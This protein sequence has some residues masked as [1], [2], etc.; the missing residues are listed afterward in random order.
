MMKRV[1]SLSRF[2]FSLGVSVLVHGIL[3]GTAAWWG[4]QHRTAA[5]V[6]VSEPTTL[7]LLAAPAVV[8]ETIRE[9]MA[10]EVRLPL[11]PVELP[12]APDPVVPAAEPLPTPVAEAIVAVP[13]AAV[14]SLVAEK[15]PPPIEAHGDASSPVPGLD[16]TTAN[17]KPT[18][19]AHPDYR[20]NPEPDYPVAARRRGQQGTVVLLVMVDAGGKPTEISVQQTSGFELLDQAAVR[21]V[22]TWEFEPARVGTTP[23]ASRI[24][25]PVRFT[26]A[27]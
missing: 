3:L 14:E 4:R 5:V 17:G 18:T 2:K 23:V 26:L 27:R 24:E 15:S 20:R 21:A 11:Q 25:V 19:S 12:R 10:P 7:E 22:Q 16:A 13:K 8:A 1:V 9:E 6:A